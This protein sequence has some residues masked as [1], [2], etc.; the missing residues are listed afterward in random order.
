MRLKPNSAMSMLR[1]L[2]VG[3]TAVGDDTPERTVGRPLPVDMGNPMPTTKRTSP[4]AWT[5]CRTAWFPS[6]AQTKSPFSNT[7]M[8]CG[9]FNSIVSAG[10][11]CEEKPP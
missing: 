7:A 1:P 5:N 8:P 9:D 2:S 6:S 10:A 11:G 3:I 4:V